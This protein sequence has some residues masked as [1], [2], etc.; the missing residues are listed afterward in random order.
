MFRS[1]ANSSALVRE[2]Q[3]A[4]RNGELLKKAKELLEDRGENNTPPAKGS[5]PLKLRRICWCWV[6]PFDKKELE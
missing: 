5:E 4:R 2:L 6:Q 3:K 1:R